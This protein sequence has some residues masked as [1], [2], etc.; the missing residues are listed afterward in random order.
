MKKATRALSLGII[1]TVAL[2]ACTS[3][4]RFDAGSGMSD[5]Q[6]AKNGAIIGATVGALGGFLTGDTAKERRQNAVKGAVIFGGTGALVGN[7]L[8]KQEAALRSSMGNNNVLIQNTGDRLIVTLPQ[9]ILFAT[10]SATLRPDLTSDLNALA[11][12]LQSYPNTNVQIIGHTDNVGDAGYNQRLSVARA[13]S[14]SRILMNNG[15]AA[16][17]LIAIGRGE[18]QPVSSNLTPEGRERNRRVEIVILPNA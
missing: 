6:K 8:D 15:V 16:N 3:P 2:G 18:D 17:R 12:N 11:A 10:D 5:N 4:S 14:V 13:E 7:E 1:C 9:D